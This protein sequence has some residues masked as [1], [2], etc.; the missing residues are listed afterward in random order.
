MKP[1]APAPATPEPK[2]GLSCPRCGCDHLPVLYT[3]Q[4]LGHILRVRQ[5]RHCGRRI[6]TRERQQ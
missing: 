3:R 1:E 2:R 4:K 5:C 6:T